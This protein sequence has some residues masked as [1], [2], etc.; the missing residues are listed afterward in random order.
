MKTCLQCTAPIPKSNKFCNK[1]CA[2]IYNNTHR[3]KKP[4]KSCPQ[5]SKKVPLNN[6]FCSKECGWK[7]KKKNHTIEFLK[8]R[9]RER[10]KR[11]IARRKHQTPIDED[12]SALQE[13][14]LNCPIGHEVDHIIPLSKGGAHSI[15]NV[16]YLT[17]SEN[18]HKSNKLNWLR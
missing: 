16:Q 7:H 11:Y 2:A 14:Y 5:C 4:R 13:F 1:S 10:Y 6:K 12:I 18:R 3:C 8:S 17:I 9:N 15:T